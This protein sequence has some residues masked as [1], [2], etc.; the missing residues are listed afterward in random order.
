MDRP[1]ENAVPPDDTTA[2]TPLGVGESM[3]RSGE[4]VT[5]KPDPDSREEAQTGDGDGAGPAPD[6][7]TG[8]NP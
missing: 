6:E 5:D 4:D 7:V 8:I 2:T 3:N 1:D